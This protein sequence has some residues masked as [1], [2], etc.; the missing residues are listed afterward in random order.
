MNQDAAQIQIAAAAN[1]R[2]SDAAV[3]GERGERSPDHPAFDDAHGR[4]EA[5]EG[6][7]AEPER[8]QHKQQCVRER[9]EN[10][11]AVIAVGFFGV[12]GT[13]G[14]AHGETGNADRGNVGKIVH[15]VIQKRDGVAEDAAEDFGDD[16]A[17]S[18]GHG[19]AEHRGPQR[20]VGVTVMIVRVVHVAIV[21][22]VL[23]I[24][25]GRRGRGNGRPF[26]PFYALCGA[27]RS[28]FELSGQF[29]TSP[30]RIH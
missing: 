26:A 19:P 5:L 15:R 21:M 13:L 25:A 18:G 30:P 12:G 24:V 22:A 1:E 14:P 16:Q 7:V 17:E 27:A 28:P 2:E 4:A 8:K 10:S 6:F 9:R 29:D 3:H 23:G 11:G 20:R